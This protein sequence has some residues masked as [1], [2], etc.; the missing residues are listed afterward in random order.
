MPTGKRQCFKQ[1]HDVDAAL[2]QH[3]AAGEVD[4]VHGEI[5][6]AVGHRMRRCPVRKD[7]RTR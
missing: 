7:A 2:F 4:F 3:R 6:Q 5:V 1:G